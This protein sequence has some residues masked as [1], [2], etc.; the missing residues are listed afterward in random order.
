M[1]PEDKK[2]LALRVLLDLAMKVQTGEVLI[3]SVEQERDFVR[4]HN[5]KT[6]QMEYF[7]TLP[8]K[9]QLIYKGQKGSTEEEYRL[10]KYLKDHPE[11][12]IWSTCQVSS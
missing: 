7:G 5:L 11:G 6:D 4:V 2:D 3:E 12:H 1:G 10:E 8:T 9:L